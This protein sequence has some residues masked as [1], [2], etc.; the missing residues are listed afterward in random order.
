MRNLARRKVDQCSHRKA[1][2][3]DGFT[4]VVTG[5]Y[6]MG[7][8]TKELRDEIMALGKVTTQ[9][10]LSLGLSLTFEKHSDLGL[11]RPPT[12]PRI[13][14][15][16]ARISHLSGVAEQID[17]ILREMEDIKGWPKTPLT[18]DYILSL[19]A[20]SINEIMWDGV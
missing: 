3:R 2:I 7:T 20:W 8:K 6:D 1:L 10:V 4:W 16:C 11:P 15:A 17:R 12:Y 13:Y 14:A 5:R 18:L 9:C 19:V